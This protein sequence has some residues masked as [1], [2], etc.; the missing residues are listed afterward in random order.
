M[1]LNW[2][3]RRIGKVPKQRWPIQ[4]QFVNADLMKRDQV[5]N[6]SI[7]WRVLS[8]EQVKLDTRP[9]R[10]DQTVADYVRHPPE[11]I[12][13]LPFSWAPMLNGIRY[14]RGAVIRC[15]HQFLQPLHRPP[16]PI[17]PPRFR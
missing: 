14:H 9:D 17:H 7:L 12:G 3:D 6:R 15:L 13:Q 8:A 16:N 2:F 4:T 11:E 10:L 1:E 5:L